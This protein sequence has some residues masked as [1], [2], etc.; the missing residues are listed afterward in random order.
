[1][2]SAIENQSVD[3]SFACYEILCTMPLVFIQGV[4]RN[5]LTKNSVLWQ[6]QCSL[7]ELIPQFATYI[8]SQ[9]FFFVMTLISL[10]LSSDH[11][12]T[13]SICKNRLSQHLI[14]PSA[15]CSITILHCIRILV[16]STL[17]K[18]SSSGTTIDSGQI[19]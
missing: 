5:I 7:I 9:F 17:I 14:F 13:T 8:F 6:W 1:M 10:S 11:Q 2:W 19:R 18:M 12:Y 15:H 3:L 16:L 4:K